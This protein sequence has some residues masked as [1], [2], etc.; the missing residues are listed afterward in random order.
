MQCLHAPP[1]P[2]AVRKTGREGW[3][4]A[5]LARCSPPALR[6]T[7]LLGVRGAGCRPAV[8]VGQEVIAV[9][10]PDSKSGGYA[11]FVRAPAHS[12]VA[13]P[14][15][16]EHNKAAAALKGGI[17]AYTALHYLARLTPGDT[18]LVCNG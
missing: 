15:R 14:A 13:K 7:R 2:N 16:V 1:T 12:V 10:S 9:V 17:A 5:R 11:Q 4:Q 8:Q 3:T 18:V 6:L